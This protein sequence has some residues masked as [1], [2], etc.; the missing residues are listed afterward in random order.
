M[1][2]Q[3]RFRLLTGRLETATH[4]VLRVQ[5]WV[6]WPEHE[7]DHKTL[8]VKTMSGAIILR[9]CMSVQGI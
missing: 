6:K 5:N 7:S 8:Y 1:R 3:M 2:L 4:D 9:L